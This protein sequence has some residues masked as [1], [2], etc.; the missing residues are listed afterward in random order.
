MERVTL[1]KICRKRREQIASTSNV[2]IED[3]LR[4]VNI[5]VGQDVTTRKSKDVHGY[6]GFCNSRMAPGIRRISI[7]MANGMYGNVIFSKTK[8]ILDHLLW[9]ST[10]QD[11]SAE[12]PQM[13]KSLSPRLTLKTPRSV[14]TRNSL[15]SRLK[16]VLPS[17]SHSKKVPT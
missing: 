17:T 15:K 14:L 4:A 16:S 13:R 9:L 8:T 5:L 11:I 1:P 7:K 10:V 3:H 6:S 2:K 12:L